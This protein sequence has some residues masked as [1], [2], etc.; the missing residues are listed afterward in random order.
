MWIVDWPLYARIYTG[1]DIDLLQRI[2]SYYIK[3]GKNAA[4]SFAIQTRRP[5][6]M[7]LRLLIPNLT[8]AGLQR[9]RALVDTGCSYSILST[10]I[11]QALRQLHPKWSFESFPSI[12]LRTAADTY[13]VSSAV[14]K[15]R[16]MILGST[17]TFEWDFYIADTHG[18]D[19]I[20]GQDWMAA[21]WVVPHPAVGGIFM[22]AQRRWRCILGS[23]KSVVNWA[24]R[25]K[26]EVLSSG[27]EC[28]KSRK[29]DIVPPRLQDSHSSET[30]DVNARKGDQAP[31][32]SD[33]VPHPNSQPTIPKQVRFTLPAAEYSDSDHDQH[34]IHARSNQ[35]RGVRSLRN[36][37]RKLRRSLANQIPSVP[38]SQPTAPPSQETSGDPPSY[39]HFSQMVQSASA[40]VIRECVADNRTPT[41][42]EWHQ[43]AASLQADHPDW[44]GPLPP[45]EDEADMIM[46]AMTDIEFDPDLVPVTAMSCP[47]DNILE[48]SCA[49]RI[50]LRTE[51]PLQE[52]RWMFVGDST[53]PGVFLPRIRFDVKTPPLYPTDVTGEAPILA[54]DVGAKT[55]H[56]FHD[57]FFQEFT[58]YAVCMG[59]EP[60]H[61]DPCQHMGYCRRLS[62]DEEDTGYEPQRVSI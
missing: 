4:R 17:R 45:C 23:P 12:R 57:P 16:F 44:Q 50:R 14:L 54:K 7:V 5:T 31:I 26:P 60:A 38:S 61:L 52:G 32:P 27:R 43:L 29:G 24:A 21:E 39:A 46:S 9:L 59:A 37:R 62:D 33:A 3:M 28:F 48:P 15:I 56:T 19:C 35:R 10:A 53:I 1:G 49:Q 11:C 34:I 2:W 55:V 40:S 22:F 25:V 58:C 20:L 8:V 51:I 13:V 47:Q 36:R 41:M 30:Q 18:F 6:T 42:G